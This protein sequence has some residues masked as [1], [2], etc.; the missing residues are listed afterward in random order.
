MVL[1]TTS[2]L[3]TANGY[4]VATSVD[5]ASTVAAVRKEK[6]DLILLDISFPPDTGG[7][8]SV[9][10]NGSLFAAVPTPKLRR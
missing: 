5:G 7:A 6:P 10:W 9:P 2:M 4:E 3:L 1:K 8:G